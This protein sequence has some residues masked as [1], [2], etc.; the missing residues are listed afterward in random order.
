[1]AVAV[2]SALPAQVELA[3]VLEVDLLLWAPRLLLQAPVAR[4]SL[5]ALRVAQLWLVVTP[6]P[7]VV[8]RVERAVLLQVP[9]VQLVVTLC[10]PPLD[11]PKFAIIEINY[12]GN[13]ISD[14][15]RQQRICLWKWREWDD[16][17][18]DAITPG[19]DPS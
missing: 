17:K 5:L 11:Y 16:A 6:L 14:E 9:Q 19:A 18:L 3:A 15:P 12:I 2:L 13:G 10:F 8:E 4:L 7:M 1:M